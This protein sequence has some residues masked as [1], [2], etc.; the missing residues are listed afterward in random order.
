MQYALVFYC[1]SG[2][3]ANFYRG[4]GVLIKRA[5]SHC[6]CDPADHADHM[7]FR[8]KSVNAA[9]S[10]NPPHYETQLSQDRFE[11]DQMV[12]VKALFSARNCQVC[13][14]MGNFEFARVRKQAAPT[15]AKPVF[16]WLNEGARQPHALYVKICDRPLAPARRSTLQ[17]AA[18]R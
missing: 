17:L 16:A 7:S 10:T 12:K 1:T 14:R 3:H 5:A 18:V 8:S 13:L 6:P 2:E 4:R 11:V 9:S 15:C